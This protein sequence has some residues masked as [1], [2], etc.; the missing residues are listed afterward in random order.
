MGRMGSVSAPAGSQTAYRVR[1]DWGAVGARETAAREGVVVV[2]DVL[3]FTTAVTIAV[4]RGIEVYAA[5]W[6]DEAADVAAAHDASLAVGRSGTTADSPW[7]LS[8]ATIAA[9]PFT[10]RLVLPSPNGSAIAAATGART[11]VAA[12]LRNA[13]A[14]AAWLA[15]Q[16]DRLG[17]VT[18]IAAGERWPDDS[19]RPALEDALGAGAVVAGLI[20]AGLDASPEAAAVAAMY[21]GTPDVGAAVAGC[22]SAHELI[23]RGFAA[24][25]EFAAECDVSTCVPVLTDD[26]F[27]RA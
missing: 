20:D 19:L 25:V 23:D 22:M 12:S 18:V 5:P 27:R 8:P 21:R 24:D 6:S 10:P 17:S 11:V 9:A 14:V 4:E 26:A 1:F 2:V 16:A 13:R 15:S 7:S 3:S